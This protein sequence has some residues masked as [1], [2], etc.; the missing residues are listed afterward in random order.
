MLVPLVPPEDR[1]AAQPVEETHDLGVGPGPGFVDADKSS[2]GLSADD[3][4][5][6]S[7]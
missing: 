3:R 1:P 6:R 7:L 5:A 4:V 2:V